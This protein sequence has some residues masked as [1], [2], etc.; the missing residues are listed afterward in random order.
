MSWDVPIPDSLRQAW[1]EWLKELPLLGNVKIKRPIIKKPGPLYTDLHIYSD[2][3][4]FAEGFVAF[5]RTVYNDEIDVV[6]G[7]GRSC[8]IPIKSLSNV[9]RLELDCCLY[10]C[11]KMVKV[12]SHLSFE[13]RNVYFWS[14]SQ[15]CLRLI[16]SIKTKLSVFE[17]NRVSKIRMLASH[18]IWCFTP[19]ALNVADVNTRGLTP[20]QLLA[21]DA[22]LQG[23]CNLRNTDPMKLQPCVNKKIESHQSLVKVKCSLCQMSV[24]RN[25]DKI[26]SCST[27]VTQIGA[28]DFGSLLDSLDLLQNP[29]VGNYDMRGSVQISTVST[30]LD[31]I[32]VNEEIINLLVDDFRRQTWDDYVY[33]V[34]SFLKFNFGSSPNTGVSGQLTV[35]DLAKARNA[36]LRVSQNISWSKL[37]PGLKQRS[38]YRCPKE[39]QLD[40][41]HLLQCS[42][43]LDEGSGLIKCF[44]RHANTA[45][46]YVS[47]E[48]LEKIVLPD[49]NVIVKKL[50]L[51]IHSDFQHIGAVTVTAILYRDF[52]LIR[53]LQYTTNGLS[54]CLPCK[55]QKAV[56]KSPEMSAIPRVRLESFIVPF[57]NAGID[58]TGPFRIKFCQGR[59]VTR[60]TFVLVITCLSTRAV[61]FMILRDMT[62]DAFLLALDTFNFRHNCAIAKIYS[63][64]GSNFLGGANV[65]SL[66]EKHRLKQIDCDLSDFLEKDRVKKQCL[67]RGITFHFGQSATPHQQ[68]YVEI[69]VGLL[70]TMLYRVIGPFSSTK[71]LAEL[72]SHDFDLILAKLAYA[73]NQRPL[74]PMSN[75]NNDLDFISPASFLKTPIADRE[76]N[77]FNNFEQFFT[78]SRELCNKYLTDMWRI[79]QDLYIPSLFIRQKWCI[80]LKPFQVG[81]LVLYK[82]RTLFSKIFH[83]GRIRKLLFGSDGIPRHVVIMTEDKKEITAPLHNVTRLECDT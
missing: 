54:H 68:G 7:M 27:N 56:T 44:G 62:T 19:G 18:F 41:K 82:P 32:R 52:W 15:Y 72:E 61:D 4:N 71:S 40:Y 36:I 21:N 28:N 65:L 29:K 14:D 81:E 9:Q 38:G 55:V 45:G 20:K 73:I 23:P 63:D 25:D 22:L 48:S 43:F 67:S 47:E 57:T 50:I 66:E 6:F 78:A 75:D 5:F 42:A 35:N 10:A 2:S 39:L 60:K 13:L 12:I 58:C 37:I 74:T 30:A 31:D 53:A 70:K 51:S 69:M 8:I 3:S 34:A 11:E 17:F 59:N 80:P 33:S 49:K 77:T 1:S 16:N 64:Q 79:W 26:D 83:V 46:D 24:G 76:G